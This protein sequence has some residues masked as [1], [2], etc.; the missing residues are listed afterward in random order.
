[1]RG[2]Q[3]KSSIAALVVVSIISAILAW[4]DVGRRPDGAIRGSR[5][6]WRVAM[7]LNTGNSF[8]YWVCGRK[9]HYSAE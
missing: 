4:R 6:G 7:V 8:A 2:T 3:R 1:M 5:T 9:R